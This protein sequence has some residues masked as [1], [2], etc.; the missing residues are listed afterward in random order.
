LAQSLSRWEEHFEQGMQ[1]PSGE[2]IFDFERE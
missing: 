1:R 2:D